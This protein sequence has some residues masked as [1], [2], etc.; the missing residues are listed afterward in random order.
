[1]MVS[2]TEVCNEKSYNRS[3]KSIEF[4]MTLKDVLVLNHFLESEDENAR[5][6]SRQF[7]KDLKLYEQ[8]F[9]LLLEI[10]YFLYDTTA[11]SQISDS[12]TAVLLIMPRVI[13]SIQ[14]VSILNLKG[15]YY[16][17]SILERSLMESIGL[18][19][20]LGSNKEEASRWLSGKSIKSPSIKLFDYVFKLMDA[21]GYSSIPAYGWMSKYVHTDF[22]AIVSLIADLHPPKGDILPKADMQFS[23]L[24]DKQKFER[25]SPSPIAMLMVLGIIFKD[26]LKKRKLRRILNQVEQLRILYGKGKTVLSRKQKGKTRRIHMQN[27]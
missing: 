26:D 25:I 19:A 11:S 6:A 17:K 27:R 8:S 13:Q 16:D 21:E 24:F 7:K 22:R 2:L 9:N 4:G 1:M 12:K 10:T 20:Y 5:K 23:P 14:S 15:Y 3:D 18:C